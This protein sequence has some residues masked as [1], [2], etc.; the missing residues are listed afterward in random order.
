[1]DNVQPSSDIETFIKLLQKTAERQR[2]Q[3]HD[4]NY[5]RNILNIST[6]KVRLKRI[7]CL[8][9]ITE[10]IAGGFI[11]LWRH[12]YYLHVGQI[13]NIAVH[14]PYALHWE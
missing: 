1:M 9:I 13:I 7:F 10:P 6:G 11:D 3:T 14:A 4:K 8:L 12:M 5:Y 2:F